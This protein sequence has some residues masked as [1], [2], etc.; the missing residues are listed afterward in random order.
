MSILEKKGKKRGILTRIVCTADRLHSRKPVLNL[1]SDLIRTLHTERRRD[2]AI[3]DFQFP[4]RV[5]VEAANALLASTLLFGP[6]A[7]E[8]AGRATVRTEGTRQATCPVGAR[9]MWDGH[10]VV[11]AGGARESRGLYSD[12]ATEASMVNGSGTVAQWEAVTRKL[13]VRELSVDAPRP[14]VVLVGRRWD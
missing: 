9:A 7:L 14:V 6:R 12:P 13:A 2:C 4:L 8:V 5:A 3:C 11:V 10:D 1:D